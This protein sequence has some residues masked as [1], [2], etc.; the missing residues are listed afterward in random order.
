M[1]A[2]IEIVVDGAPVA[3][4]PGQTIAAAMWRANRVALRTGPGGA[5]RA[6]YCGIGVCTECRV[7]V[8]GRG[9][10]R[11]CTTPAEPAMR[12]TTGLP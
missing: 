11:A 8:E 5:P 4:L 12:V 1:S 9:V 7:H 6:V 2:E 10:V 3:A